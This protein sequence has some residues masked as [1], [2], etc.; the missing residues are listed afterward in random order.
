M[1]TEDHISN[2]S[3]QGRVIALFDVR[4]L[5]RYA[6][7]TSMDGH[8]Y[9]YD[10]GRFWHTNLLED[11]RLREQVD[12]PCRVPLGPWYHHSRCDCEICAP[13]PE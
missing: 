2:H 1:A 9:E 13:A 8:L 10:D 7:H 12:D 4:R 5:E 6:A 3:A 11:V